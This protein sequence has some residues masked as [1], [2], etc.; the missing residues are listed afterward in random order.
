MKKFSRISLENPLG[1][2][3]VITEL[4]KQQNG[5]EKETRCTNLCHN[6]LV[7]QTE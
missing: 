4:H 7:M 5:A 3:K 2:M 6:S 1:I